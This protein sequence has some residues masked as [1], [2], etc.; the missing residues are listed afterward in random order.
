MEALEELAPGLFSP[1]ILGGVKK[2][3]INPAL[4]DAP[5]DVLQV[6]ADRGA[7]AALSIGGE[8]EH[9]IGTLE[10]LS[11]IVV[12]RR[13][14]WFIVYLLG[15]APRLSPA[16]STP[17]GQRVP[18]ELT[19]PVTV[20]EDESLSLSEQRSSKVL[21]CLTQRRLRTP[22]REEA[23]LGVKLYVDLRSD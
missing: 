23:E 15:K 22:L 3:S 7:K 17:L 5:V 21:C 14:L 19:E 1:P 16:N 4:V 12:P 2:P 18:P 6:L 13:V 20:T 11:K 9:I 8:P 10:S